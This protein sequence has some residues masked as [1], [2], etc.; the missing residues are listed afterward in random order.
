M[1]F[2]GDMGGL[3]ISLDSSLVH[4]LVAAYELGV[5]W[6]MGLFVLLWQCGVG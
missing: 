1:K 2:A 3:F 4:A 6:L 5:C